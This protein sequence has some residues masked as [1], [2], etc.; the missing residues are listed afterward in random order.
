[1]NNNQKIIL[2][3]GAVGLSAYLIYKYNKGIELKS[4]IDRDIFNEKTIIV[5]FCKQLT[6]FN[7]N[8]KIHW[9]KNGEVI[10]INNKLHHGVLKVNEVRYSIQF[11]KVKGV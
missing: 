1:M 8:G 10:E 3:L 9:I 5:N 7:Y 4:H 2:G 6:G 11:R